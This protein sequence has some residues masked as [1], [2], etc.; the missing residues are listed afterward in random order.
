MS[1]NHTIANGSSATLRPSRFLEPVQKHV[2]NGYDEK[3]K[4][5]LIILN[6]PLSDYA[7]TQRL[8]D[9]ASFRVCA[10][11]GANRLHD[12][13][14]AQ[15]PKLPLSE[16]LRKMVPD[17]IHGDLD[18]LQ[19]TVRERWQQIGVK[20]SHDPDQYSTDFGKAIKKVVEC[21]PA[22]KDILVLG[23][24]GGRVDQGIGLLHELYRE[25]ARRHTA[26]RFTLFT[27]SSITVV[28]GQGQT[29]IETPLKTGLIRENIGILPLYGPAVISTQG[30]EWDVEDWPTEMG[31]QVSTSNH[32]TA[33]QITIKT[34][35]EV[36]FTVERAVE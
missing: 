3:N 7:Y 36:L 10:D 1:K 27:E 8:F 25:Q 18:S 19:D 14:V 24:L 4:V 28:L 2:C 13:S 22:V 29:T 35:R 21:L 20:V 11:G 26:I 15:N 23:S 17:L 33:D 6:S 12:L 31:G 16:A 30:L 32:I 9:H 34:D 5:A